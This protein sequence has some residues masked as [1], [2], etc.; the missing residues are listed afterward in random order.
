[1]TADLLLYWMAHL[2]EGSWDAFRGAIGR[3]APD[4]ADLAEIARGQRIFLSDLGY[5]DFFI[6]SSQR[7]RIQP[8]VVAGLVSAPN[9]AILAGGR[10]PTMYGAL[11]KAAAVHDCHITSEHNNGHPA[12]VR[13]NGSREALAAV[14]ASL[15]IPFVPNFANFACASIRPI[16][17]QLDGACVEDKPA[18]WSVRTFDLERLTWVDGLQSN[19]ACEFT[20]RYGSRRFF[21]HTKRGRLLRLPKREAVYAAALL[22][23]T[24]LVVYDAETATLAVPATAPLPELFARAAC[25]CIAQPASYDRGRLVYRSVPSSVAAIL[26]LAVGQ[27]YPQERPS[28]AAA[29]SEG[30]YG[31]SV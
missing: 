10:T 24:P 15:G 2:G 18:N 5:A 20:S 22:R 23:R 19:A 6:E 1:M 4:G 13:I 8:P 14:A 25:V 31:Q 17:A 27:R 3:L 11:T 29:P 30:P 21:V 9:S 7:W 16:Q 26:L 12:T 28:S